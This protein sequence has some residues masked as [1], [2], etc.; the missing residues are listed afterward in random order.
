MLKGLFG[1]GMWGLEVQCQF[2]LKGHNMVKVN[3]T[4]TTIYAYGGQHSW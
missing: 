2:L 1:G 3:V 4:S